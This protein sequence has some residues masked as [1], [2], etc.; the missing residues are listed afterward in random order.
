LA[1][2]LAAGIE[3][4]ATAIDDGHALGVLESLIRVSQECTQST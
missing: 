2:D 1:H 4:A 3:R